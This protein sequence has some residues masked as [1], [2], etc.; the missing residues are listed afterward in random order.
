MGHPRL[1]LLEQ[2]RSSFCHPFCHIPG[3][4]L[5]GRLFVVWVQFEFVRVRFPRLGSGQA[6]APPVKARGFG[7][8]DLLSKN[9][10]DLLM[11]FVEI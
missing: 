6:L 10:A 2:F 5:E 1:L 11:L 8:T 4:S 9:Q 7:M 3:A